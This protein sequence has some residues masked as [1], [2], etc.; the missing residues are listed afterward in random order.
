M[1][2][3]LPKH[4]IIGR[5]RADLNHS[6]NLDYVGLKEI[7][8]AYINTEEIIYEP[9]VKIM[10]GFSNS[11]QHLVRPYDEFTDVDTYFFDQNN[12]KANPHMKRVGDIYYYEP[13]SQTEYTPLT[14][15]VYLKFR[16]QEEFWNNKQYNLLV[17][18]IETNE[19]KS[20]INNLISIFADKYE[21]G[22]CPANIRINNG[23]KTAESLTEQSWQ[24]A[25]FVFIQ[26]NDGRHFGDLEGEENEISLSAILDNYTCAW[27]FVKDYDSH[28]KTV[29]ADGPLSTLHMENASVFNKSTYNVSRSSITIFDQDTFQGEG[30]DATI[31]YFYMN[32][33]IQV[34]HYHNKGFIIISPDWLLDNLAETG[35]MIY[36]TMMYCYLQR[37]YKSRRT[38]MWIT[39]EPVD[40]LAYHERKFNRRHNVVTVDELM[41]D[42]DFDY[43][44]SE[45]IDVIVTTPYVYFLGINN[46]RELLFSKSGG[47]TDPVKGLEE[48]SY[49][50]TKHTVINFTQSNLYTVETPLVV[51]VTISNS[52]GYVTVEPMLSSE[53]KIQTTT[54]QTF[55]I[56]DFT[57]EYNLYVNKGSSDIENTFFLLDRKVPPNGDYTLVAQIYFTT[58]S[59]V[60]SCDT[61]L[62]GGGL[63]SSQPDDYD[64]LDIGHVYGR[65]YRLGSA[66]IV[67]LPIRLKQFE[68]RIRAELNKHI[69]AGDEYVIVFEE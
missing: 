37:Y 27:L 64:M 54:Q 11:S 66:L 36:E 56:E 60:I 42:Y 43:N 59:K 22:F 57:T 67:R 8:L 1:K 6:N 28:F 14:F 38:T 13:I 30:Q 7:S 52:V 34:Q 55:K 21:K 61:R 69:A 53:K 58:D 26:S 4:D 68:S 20:F 33:A 63:P 15:Q 45:L 24:T 17:S 31:T 35:Q 2:I 5:T 51:N 46:K 19:D 40:Y 47:T 12:K 32:E 62:M 23:N 65:P 3:N 50:T 48:Q 41:T 39:N 16:K 44:Q 49:Y 29:L 10:D 18:A 25:D 9:H